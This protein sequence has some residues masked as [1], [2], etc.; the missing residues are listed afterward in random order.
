MSKFYIPLNFLGVLYREIKQSLTDLD[1]MFSLLEKERE[2]ADS[3]NATALQLL[4]A[5]TVRFENVEFA[6]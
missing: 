3:S 4:Q 5:P 2:I 1:R 6:Y